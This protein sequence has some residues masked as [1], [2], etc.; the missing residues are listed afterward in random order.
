VTTKPN[1]SSTALPGTSSI[2]Q[3]VS[4]TALDEDHDS[5]DATGSVQPQTKDNFDEI[6]RSLG[7]E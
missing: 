6:E 1:L 3:Q 5:G 7:L 4:T 2:T